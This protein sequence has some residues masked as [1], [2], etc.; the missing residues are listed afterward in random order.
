MIAVN[1]L[2]GSY[3]KDYTKNRSSVYCWFGTNFGRSI[4]TIS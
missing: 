3:L 2:F 4:W 1:R